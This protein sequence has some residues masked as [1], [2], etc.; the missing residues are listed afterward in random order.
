MNTDPRV[1]LSQE[2]TASGAAPALEALDRTHVIIRC[3]PSQG[4]TASAL[5]AAALLALVMRT[6]AHVEPDDDLPLPANPWNAAS[7]QDL[8]SKLSSLR[9][10]P[11]AS[12]AKISVVDVGHHPS[13]TIRRADLRIGGDAWTA[14]TTGGDDL[15]IL[16]SRDQASADQQI[17]YGNLLAAG[18][19]AAHLFREILRPLGLPACPDGADLIWNV[20]THRRAPAPHALATLAAAPE[21]PA[22]AWLGCGSV[23]SSAVAALACENLHGLASWTIDTDKFDQGHN[24]FRYPASTGAETGDKAAWLSAILG[25]SGAD[26]SPHAGLVRDWIRTR[27]EPGFYGI[28]VCG[29]DTIDGRYEAADLLARTTLSAAVSGMALHLQREHLGDGYRCPYCDFVDLRTPLSQAAA[30]AALTGLDE[31]R[32]IELIN[33]PQGLTE[34]DISQLIAHGKI[35]ASSASALLGRRLADV[36]GRIYA[37]GL[38]PAPVPGTAPTPVSAPFVSWVSGVL[39]AA[40]I[41]KAARGLPLIDRRVELD[42]H[43]LPDDFVLRLAQD[44]SGRCACASIVR[45][46]WIAKLY[47]RGK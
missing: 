5:G 44:T 40:E 8:Y 26:C 25:R 17:P 30:D 34:G 47:G 16:I 36:R 13:D 20:L 23:N 31:R 22:V 6:H 4:N 14:A 7:L 33:D 41:A 46:R 39:C 45:R 38:I 11:A 35:P 19:G 29:V 37:E 28:A 10:A 18:F 24:P 3:Q 1:K 15:P 2:L 27:T 32:V 43:G 12:P 21:W 9:P 42:L